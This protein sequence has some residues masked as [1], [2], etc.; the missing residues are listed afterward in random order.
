MASILELA[1]NPLLSGLTGGLLSIGT[2]VLQFFQKK[3]DNAHQLLLKDKER[4]LLQLTANLDAARLAGALAQ[5]REVGASAAFVAS[6]ENEGRIRGEHKTI[7][8]LRASVR[9][10][11]TYVYQ[12]A[13]FITIGTA[14]L[15]WFKAWVPEASIE[16]L[17]QFGVVSIVNTATLTISWYFG[18]R[19][20][21]RVSVA[22][23]NTQAGASV[24]PKPTTL[25]P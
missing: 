18:Q 14:I 25:K 10:V 11:L 19:A 12:A 22:W 21:D 15:A 6:I 24:G 5:A 3:Q 4:E 8:S 16:P 9:P 13:F 2:G 7:T 1:A 20:Q 23:G 17:V